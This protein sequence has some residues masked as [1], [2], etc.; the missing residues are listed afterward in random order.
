[1]NDSGT[2]TNGKTCFRQI[3]GVKINATK[4]EI[5]SM[6]VLVNTVVLFLNVD[7]ILE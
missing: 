4:Y 7:L 2:T 5:K 1:M 3:L 6:M